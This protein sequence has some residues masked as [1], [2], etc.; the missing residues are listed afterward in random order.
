MNVAFEIPE[1]V[2]PRLAARW[3]D[4]S[5][6]SLE[7]VAADAYRTGVLTAQEVQRMLDLPSRWEVEAFL[8]RAQAHLDYTEADLASDL[9]TLRRLGPG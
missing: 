8:K 7:A 5:R 3:G 9:A 4:L 1:E 2:S 6:R